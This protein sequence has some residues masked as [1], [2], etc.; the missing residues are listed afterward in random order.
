MP[1]RLFAAITRP[2]WMSSRLN[3]S[4][5]N[6]KCPT[7]IILQFT[8]IFTRLKIFKNDKALW[9]EINLW[10]LH[11]IFCCEHIN[12]VTVFYSHVVS[13]VMRQC[14]HIIIVAAGSHSKLGECKLTRRDVEGN[15]PSTWDMSGKWIQLTKAFG[16]KGPML[17]NHACTLLSVLSEALTE[18][19]TFVWDGKFINFNI[20]MIKNSLCFSVE[21]L[22][23]VWTRFL[24]LIIIKSR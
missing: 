14:V 24:I 18:A 20:R 8:Q 1:C 9:K 12:F 5:S 4:K 2:E 10:K 13:F 15:L 17:C 21:F 6:I 22:M 7:L 3:S 11:S 23:M 16:N 19:L